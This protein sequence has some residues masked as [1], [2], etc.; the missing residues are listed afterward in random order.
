M[1]RTPAPCLTVVGTENNVIS[2]KTMSFKG[3]DFEA[4]RIRQM[5]ME[6]RLTLSEFLRRRASGP[7]HTPAKP[8][9]VRCEFTGAMIF[10]PL[11]ERPPLTSEAV[12]ELDADFP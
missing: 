11:V 8:Q 6:E 3:T 4:R 12:K 9:R 1:L 10:A 5:A 2:M 7:P